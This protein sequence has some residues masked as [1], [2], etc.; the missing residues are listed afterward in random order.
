MDTS[1]TELTERQKSILEKIV[2]DYISSAQPISSLELG[3]RHNF[4]IKP[5]MMRI[6]MEKLSDGGYLSQPFVSS[7]R[8]P[9]DKAYRFFVDWILKKGVPEF[10]GIKAISVVMEQ[11]REDLFKLAIETV[12]F[13]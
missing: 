5:A 11:E 10:A 4:G 6:E 8:V 12:Q 7:G 2:E 13:L 9:T 3:K 1:M